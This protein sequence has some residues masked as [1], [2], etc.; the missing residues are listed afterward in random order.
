MDKF[1]ILSR[2]QYDC[3]VK[4]VETDV[5]ETITQLAMNCASHSIGIHVKDQ[6]GK[7]L[8]VRKTSD[9]DDQ[10]PLRGD[11]TVGEAGLIMYDCV[12][13]YFSDPES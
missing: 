11:I 3:H 10:P 9:T 8:R 12:D 4:V 2:F 7:V 5:G 1:P 13:V 6:L